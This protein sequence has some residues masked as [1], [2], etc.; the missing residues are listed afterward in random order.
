MLKSSKTI[1]N[2]SDGSDITDNCEEWYN[3]KAEKTVAIS[4]HKD[5]IKGDSVPLSLPKEYAQ[6]V[7]LM[8]L[9]TK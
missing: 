7:E 9:R 6:K 5:I 2:A 1:H 8:R 4:C 3:Y